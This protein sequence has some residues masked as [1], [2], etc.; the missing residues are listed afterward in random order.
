MT[1]FLGMKEQAL[2]GCYRISGCKAGFLCTISQATLAKAQSYTIHNVP[3]DTG[4]SV[5]AKSPHPF[6]M[7]RR[8]GPR[9]H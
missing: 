7:F 8:S 5:K 4:T 9:G 6:R 2:G 3:S 1:T